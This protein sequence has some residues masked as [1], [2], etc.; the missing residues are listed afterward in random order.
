MDARKMKD[1]SCIVIDQFQYGDNEQGKYV[2]LKPVNLSR[3]DSLPVA[4]MDSEKEQ[5]IA[6]GELTVLQTT[7]QFPMG[8]M[9]IGNNAGFQVIVDED[10]F[11]KLAEKIERKDI[12]TSSY[13]CLQSKDPMK[14]QTEI[15]GLR[16]A[17]DTNSIY[18]FNTYQ[19]RQQEEQ[20]MML[21]TVFVYGFIIL[22]TAICIANIFNTIS[23][24]IALRKREFAMLKSV[25]MTPKGFNKMINYESI[26]YG[27]KALLYGLPASVLM[28]L[29]IYYTLTKQ[30]NFGFM[31]PWTEIAVAMIAVFLIVSAAMLYSISK[32]KKENII[33]AL[34]QEN[35]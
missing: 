12:H 29:F 9:P 1:L 8:V 22:I 17:S 26:F 30:F 11:H 13:L 7:D 20:L 27:I 18:I 6:L 16:D 34:K 23:T 33:D 32:V 15:E 2:E 10:V 14:L 21:L 31:L 19:M 3:G 4:Y 24:S 5:N 25:G 35:I 28:I